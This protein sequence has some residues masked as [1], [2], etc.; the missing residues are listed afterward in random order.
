MRRGD[1]RNPL[2]NK[3]LGTREQEFPIL[4]RQLKLLRGLT[5]FV[6]KAVPTFY[7]DPASARFLSYGR[8][9]V[10]VKL[11]I[12]ALRVLVID[13]VGPIQLKHLHIF[14]FQPLLLRLGENNILSSLI[15][16]NT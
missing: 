7:P 11:L 15:L 10:E 12:K 13:R 9:G 3:P 4:P 14:K 5:R 6:H 8:G 2:A 1:L 16:K